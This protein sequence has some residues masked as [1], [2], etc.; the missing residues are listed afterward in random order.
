M[1]KKPAHNQQPQKQPTVTPP[2]LTQ[3][4]PE[5]KITA[6]VTVIEEYKPSENSAK[7]PDKEKPKNQYKILAARNDYIRLQEEVVKHLNDGWELVGGVSNSTSVGQYESV[8]IF[9]QAVRR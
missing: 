1:S 9:V 4:K 3:T 5:V 2:V 8:T 7:Y 6:P